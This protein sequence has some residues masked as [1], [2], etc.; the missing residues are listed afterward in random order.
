MLS[1]DPN[2]YAIRQLGSV[3]TGAQPDCHSAGPQGD[4]SGKKPTIRTARELRHQEFEPIRYVVPGYIA[5]GLTLLAGPPKLGKSWL[6]LDAGL[7][8]ATGGTC[9]GGLVCEQGDVLYLALEDKERRLQG[10]IA[11]L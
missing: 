5:E 1:P 7:A 8:L 10:R 4:K 6:V 3:R 9:L 2:S 11:A